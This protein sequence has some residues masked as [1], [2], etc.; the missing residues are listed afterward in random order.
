M[1]LGGD[2]FYPPFWAVLFG[3]CSLCRSFWVPFGNFVGNVA[4]RLE[5]WGL[6]WSRLG[7]LLGLVCFCLLLEFRLSMDS[8]NSLNII[9]TFKGTA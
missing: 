9:P 6:F 2:T 4:D 1:D 8:V 5:G 3:L 7:G